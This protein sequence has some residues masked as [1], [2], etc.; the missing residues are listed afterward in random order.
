MPSLTGRL[1]NTGAFQ[2]PAAIS[3]TWDVTMPAALD[4]ITE[5][6][7][8]QETL[9]GLATRELRRARRV[10]PL[11][12][13]RRSARRAD[14]PDTAGAPFAL[15]PVLQLD[16]TATAARLS[17]EALI[18]ALRRAFAEEGC[19]FPCATRTASPTRRRRRQRAA[20]AG[21][22][23]GGLFGL[24]T[25]MI[26]PGSGAGL[27]GCTRSAL[28]DAS[29]GVPL[30]QLDGNEITSPHRRRRGIGH[31]PFLARGMHDAIAGARLRPRRACC[32]AAMRC[33]RPITRD[34]GVEPPAR[35]AIAL[36]REWREQ[37]IDARA[38][39]DLDAAVHE[40]DIVSCATLASAALV[41]ARGCARHAPRPDR[42]LHA[43]DARVT[44]R[45]SRAAASSST[46]RRLAKSGD[47]L[48]MSPRARSRSGAAAGHA[49][50]AGARRARAAARPARSRSSR[51][52][53]TR[54]KTSPLQKSLVAAAMLGR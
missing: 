12:R 45:A 1:V 8:F 44:R 3:Q 30:A 53:A 46:P 47:V 39:T 9:S 49:G 23:P 36:A 31:C 11:L 22:K 16:A 43:A 34:A 15:R 24:K 27:P 48:G 40:V 52:W 54:S 14:C 35:G 38:V 7:P 41:R 37:G 19:K 21:L 42:Q 50:A 20:D 26:F 5:S 32:P 4:P 13:G 10:P 33:V 17:F 29:T 18:L 6:G 2:N 51:R 28:F 25:V